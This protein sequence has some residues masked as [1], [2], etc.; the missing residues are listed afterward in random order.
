[1]AWSSRFISELANPARKPVW[2]FESLI[3]GSAPIGTPL[4]FASAPGLGD[5]QLLGLRGVRVQGQTLSPSS[6]TTTVGEFSV[7]IVGDPTALFT[8]ITRGTVCLVR[9]GFAGWAESDFEIIALGQV[10]NMRRATALS[11]AVDCRDLFSAARTRLTTTAGQLALFY[12]LEAAATTMATD[13]YAVG[14]AD[15]T[16][17][18]ASVF[19]RETGGTGVVRVTPTSGDDFF[20]LWSAKTATVLTLSE[21]GSE[22]FA[23]TRAAAGIGQAVQGCAYLK[24]H[25]CD[26]VRRILTSGSGTGVYDDYPSAWGIGLPDFLFD[27]EDI[28]T[29]RDRVVVPASGSWEWEI[30]VTEPKT[31]GFAWLQD[32]LARAGMFLAMRQGLVTV[33]ALQAQGSTTYTYHSNLT[34][35]DEDIA[36]VLEWEAF[37]SD[38][39]EEYAEVEVTTLDASAVTESTTSTSEDPATLPAADTRPFDLGSRVWNNRSAVRTEV[40]G[41]VKESAT[42]VPER[43]RLRLVP[44]SWAQLAPGDPVFLSTT[45]IWGRLDGGAYD[46]RGAIVVEVSPDYIVGEVDVSLVVYPQT[47]A[48]FAT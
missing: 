47:D 21:S 44:L 28:E 45:K 7:D 48:V 11:W 12:D 24:G 29:F 41:R 31:D 18:D 22:H 30:V 10:R 39:G 42:R 15:I 25:P 14:D 43:L 26:V 16:V 36:E 4:R 2:I 19:A 33:R 5:Y 27:H 8:N 40:V 38:V 23:T 35:T 6:S 37:D 32:E 46:G 1:M 13:A 3:A 20:L 9:M 34:I 17:A